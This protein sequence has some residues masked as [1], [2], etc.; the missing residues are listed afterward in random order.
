[1]DVNTFD[2]RER[3][4]IIPEVGQQVDDRVADLGVQRLA[5][6]L[7]HDGTRVVLLVSSQAEHQAEGENLKG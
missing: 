7:S 2:L 1:M 5:I 4:L 6:S 3:I